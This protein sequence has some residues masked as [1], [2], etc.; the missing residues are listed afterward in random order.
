MAFDMKTIDELSLDELRD[1][2][3]RVANR[4]RSLEALED[5]KAM[6][7]YKVGQKVEFVAA[8]GKTFQGEIVKV[9]RLTAKVRTPDKKVHRVVPSAMKVVK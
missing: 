2:Q 9:N 4:L 6:F 1:V 7:D 5:A 3:A 8:R